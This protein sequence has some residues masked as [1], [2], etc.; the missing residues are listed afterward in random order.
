MKRLLA[1]LISLCLL[2][3]AFTLVACEPNEE[4]TPDQEQQEQAPEQPDDS[5]AEEDEVVNYDHLV[6]P[7]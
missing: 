4:E 7:C 3:S 6:D 2:L 1:L 5:T